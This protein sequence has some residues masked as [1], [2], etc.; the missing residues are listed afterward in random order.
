V[1]GV[2]HG[3]RTDEDGIDKTSPGA[4]PAVAHVSAAAGAA[5]SGTVRGVR[6]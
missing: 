1:T 2:E 6:W 3:L 4:A 5:E